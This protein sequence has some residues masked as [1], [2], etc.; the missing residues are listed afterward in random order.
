VFQFVVRIFCHPVY[1]WDFS[2]N[3][4]L[5]QLITD[6]LHSFSINAVALLPL[7][8]RPSG[9][10]PFPNMYT[11]PRA[12]GVSVGG[13]SERPVTALGPRGNVSKD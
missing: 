2:T 6:K 4:S 8:S 7:G 11:S 9:H 10:R 12:A 13:T 3:Y 1:V 5:R